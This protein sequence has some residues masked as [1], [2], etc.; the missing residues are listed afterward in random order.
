MHFPQ[1]GIR[2]FQDLDGA[3]SQRSD[4]KA[5]PNTPLDT[6]NSFFDHV[7]NEKSH[8]KGMLLI[9]LMRID[10]LR[11][12]DQLFQNEYIVCFT[13]ILSVSAVLCCAVLCYVVCFYHH[14]R[15]RHQWI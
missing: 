4:T 1:G 15:C 12:L 7:G 8:I 3:V 11:Y 10:Q 14:R 5:A 6:Q 2:T 9:N 13:T